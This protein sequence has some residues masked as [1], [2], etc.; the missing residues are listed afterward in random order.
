MKITELFGD[1]IGAEPSKEADY[2]R[3]YKEV[4]IKHGLNF[5]RIV[6]ESKTQYR[7]D[8]PNE[9]VVFNSNIAIVNDGK[10]SGKIWYGDVNITEDLYTLEAIRAEL[11]VD[12]LYI[13]N[14]QDLRFDKEYLT[15]DEVIDL[16]YLYYTI[17]EGG[18]LGIHK[19]SPVKE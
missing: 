18:S 6:S 17:E 5:G 1:P 12:K 2:R 16:C 8:H 9:E 10:V 19:N 15:I 11:G 4:F 7:L 3:Q 14:E 13:F